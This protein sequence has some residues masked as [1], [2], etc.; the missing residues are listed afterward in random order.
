MRPCTPGTRAKGEKV[1]EIDL[2]DRFFFLFLTKS[3]HEVLLLVPKD[4]IS[5]V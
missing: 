1:N 5:F 3:L 4:L 2:Y